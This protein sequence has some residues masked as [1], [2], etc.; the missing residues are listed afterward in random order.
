[1]VRKLNFSFLLPN[2][3]LDTQ[4][5]FIRK[6]SGPNDLT[7]YFETLILMGFLSIKL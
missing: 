2:K 1:M 4:Q 7:I 6:P 3:K 5:L